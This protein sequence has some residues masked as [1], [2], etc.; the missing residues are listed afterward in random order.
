[1][2]LLCSFL[3]CGNVIVY[4]KED[5]G[6]VYKSLSVI[7]EVNDAREYRVKET[8]TID[9]QKE[10]HGI[11]RDIPK[12]SSVEKVEIEDVH[13]EG[14]HYTLQN[15]TDKMLIKIGDADEVVSGERQLTLTY[16]LK[17][18]QDYD[19]DHDYVYVNVLGTDYDSEVERF[20]A[21]VRFPSEERLEKYRVLSGREG[22][23]SNI[24]TKTY[25]EG[26]TIFVDSK[27][28]LRPQ[29]GVSVQLRFEEGT[30]GNAPVYEVPYLIKEQDM[31][32][33]LT[34]E[35]DFMVTQTMKVQVK[36]SYVTLLVPMISREWDNDV[37]RVDDVKVSHVYRE[38]IDNGYIQ[39]TLEE[40]THSVNISYLL[41]PYRI[42]S[43]TI[44]LSLNAPE[45]DTRIEQLTLT[46]KSPDIVKPNV[47]LQ[48][49]SDQTKNDRYK[50][51]VNG[52]TLTL[53]TLDTM[54]A[55]EVLKLSFE[56]DS[57]CFHRST[58]FDQGTFVA[59]SI[60]F[61]MVIFCLRFVKYRNKELIV[62]ISFDPPKGINPAEAGYIMDK[63]L[64]NQDITSLI[65]YWA[66]QG[67]LKIH[68]VNDEY[69]FEKLKPVDLDAP[70]YEQTLM[71]EMFSYGSKDGIVKKENLKHV[72]YIDIKHARKSII[73]KYSGKKALRD[74]HVETLRKI[75]LVASVLPIMLYYVASLYA[76]HENMY[77]PVVLSLPLIPI[78]F[79]IAKLLDVV[80]KLKENDGGFVTKAIAYGFIIFMLGCMIL[81]LRLEFTPALAICV[82]SFILSLIMAAGLHAHTAYSKELLTELLGFKEFI[83]TA[84]KDQLEL[85]LSEDPDF[86]YHVLPYAQV[87]HVSDIWIHKFKDISVQPPQWYDGDEDFHYEMMHAMVHDMQQDMKQASSQPVAR[88]GSSSDDAG[89][90]EGFSDGGHTGGGSGG[91]GSR[92]W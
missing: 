52:D 70:V 86:Y 40:G 33:Q 23:S 55:A 27:E 21:E 48:R 49:K 10:M 73:K 80:K 64:S 30:F 43:D 57:S 36:D 9:F 22:T 6:Y 44:T 67:Y 60:F 7:V 37:Y 92:G 83:E 31:N 34:Q 72:F 17:H 3:F 14:M 85:L 11:I 89:R 51:E 8:M 25:K 79:I 47:Y 50:V 76:V 4:A 87:L 39:I 53:H 16:T 29:I 56:L 45:N 84:E 32:I 88:G 20:H 81:V 82:G 18:Y 75:C 58:T 66:D 15:E 13:V 46:M 38:S 78:V 35:Q 5:P 41:H 19:H 26:D 90:G 65:F 54:E 59:L 91:G 61:L 2:S 71:K 42:M 1:M 74:P 69:Y 62:P 63:K 12:S 28:T 68:H 24:Y 77:L